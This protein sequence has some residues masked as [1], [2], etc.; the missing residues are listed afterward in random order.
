MEEPGLI[1]YIFA[2][3]PFVVF[4]YVLL[5]LVAKTNRPKSKIEPIPEKPPEGSGWI[6]L[7]EREGYLKIGKVSYNLELSLS[8]NVEKHLTGRDGRFHKYLNSSEFPGV[9]NVNILYYNFFLEVEEWEKKIRHLLMGYAVVLNEGELNKLENKNNELDG[10]GDTDPFRTK[11]KLLPNIF[12]PQ[13]ERVLDQEHSK[14]VDM[15]EITKDIYQIHE[16]NS[17]LSD[18]IR[19]VIS[20]M[21]SKNEGVAISAPENDSKNPVIN[22]YFLRVY[23]NR[24]S[25]WFKIVD[26]NHEEK[27]LRILYAFMNTFRLHGEVARKIMEKSNEEIFKKPRVFLSCPPELG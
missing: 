18:K 19:E 15:V 20:E 7:I 14:E 25:E 16:Y 26:M 9:M 23:R 4:L 5:M 2:A 12:Y 6:Y 8:E 11:G 21:Q 27:E 22:P 10:S 3:F 17:T 24:N 1:E 13:E